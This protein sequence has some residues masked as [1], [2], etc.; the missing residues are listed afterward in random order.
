[1]QSTP[2]V[3]AAGD[4]KLSS[5]LKTCRKLND[6][7]VRI[8]HGLWLAHAGPTLIHVSRQTLRCKNYTY[9]AAHPGALER[10]ASAQ[11]PAR[12]QAPA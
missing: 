9:A 1:L 10:T 12:W 5:F 7:R 2:E 11:G 8:V 6:E 3:P 4:E